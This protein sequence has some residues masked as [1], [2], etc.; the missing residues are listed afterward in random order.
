LAAWIQAAA[1]TE[2][3]NFSRQRTAETAWIEAAWLPGPS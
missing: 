3:R 2:L 1:E